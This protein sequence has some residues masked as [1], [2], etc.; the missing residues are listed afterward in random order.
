MHSKAALIPLVL[1][2]SSAAVSAADT[3]LISR[4]SQK[5]QSNGIS[6]EPA[7]SQTGQFVAYRSS[8]TNLDSDRC[9]GGLNQVYGSD[10]STGTIR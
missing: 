10:R 8:A 5:K 9:D 6:G 3:T 7:T 2:L 4:K 1:I